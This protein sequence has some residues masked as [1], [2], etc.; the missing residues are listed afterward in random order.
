MTRHLFLLSL[1]LVAACGKDTTTASPAVPVT[2][3]PA[4]VQSVP[5]ELA[6]VG[7]VEPIQTVVVQPQVTGQLIEVLFREGDEVR[8]GQPLFRIDARPFQA[9]L[10]QAEAILARDRAQAENAS[11]ELERFTGLAQ[12]E[13]ITAQQY[14]QARATATAAQAT[15]A[16]DQAAVD[17]ARLNLQHATIT[18]PI[19][20]R[21]GSLQIRAG[22]LVRENATALVTINQIRPI[23][24]RFA[25]PAS[26]LGM[27]QRYRNRRIAVRATPT[28]GGTESEGE[29]S[30]VDNS[31]DSSTG[32]ILLKA[33][34]P[35]R[36]GALWPGGFVNVRA[37]LFTQDSVLVVPA[38][39]VM[40]GQ[41]GN[42][43]F[44]VRDSAAAVAR[45]TVEREAD[46][47]AVIT[48]EVQPGDAVVTDG[49][50]LLRPGARVQVRQPR[51]APDTTEHP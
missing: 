29:L 40:G 22:N 26:N 8:A 48:G 17:Q 25:V 37:R 33:S 39:A 42:Y 18:A 41:Q 12:K 45:V 32:T 13:Y 50:L 10:A 43:V 6:A 24:V 20:G 46:G 31:V 14:D 44:V 51:A 23:L 2:V 19:A 11:Q 7:T 4:A 36:D 28:G 38:V 5:Y 16:A 30:F 15:L 49:Q 34:F 3:A 9:A 27:I 35:N 21:T 1:L 47:L